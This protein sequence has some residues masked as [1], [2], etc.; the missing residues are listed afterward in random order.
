MN[1][2]LIRAWELGKE[3]GWYWAKQ[4]VVGLPNDEKDIQDNLLTQAVRTIG[5]EVI[6]DVAWEIVRRGHYQKAL[7]A[8]KETCGLPEEEAMNSL[9]EHA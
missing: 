6:Y 7:A 9:K 2:E 4:C 1:K 3:Y 5:P 8:F